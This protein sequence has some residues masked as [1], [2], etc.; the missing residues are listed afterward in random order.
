[1]AG[2][3]KENRLRDILSRLAH[4]ELGED[5]SALDWVTG[6]IASG[7]TVTTLTK[8]LAAEFREESCSRG[9]VSTALNRLTDDAKARIEQAR[10]QAAGVLIDEALSI[11]DEVARST[12]DVQRNR[13]RA[14]ARMRIAGWWDKEQYGDSK[15][16]TVN[17]DLPAL[18][19]EALR[20]RSVEQAPTLALLGPGDQ[21]QSQDEPSER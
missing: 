10:K 7:V 20:I 19:L 17:L 13:L 1:V 8:I 4:E 14:D 15:G 11:V 2:R 18:H 6:K 3:P 21:T 12:A 16:V 5:A 9:W